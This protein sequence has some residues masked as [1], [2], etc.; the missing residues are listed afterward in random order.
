MQLVRDDT[1][2]KRE[3]KFFKKHQ[4]LIG[5]YAKVLKLLKEDYTHPSLKL[6]PLKGK[7][8][9]FH[10]ISLT[11]EYRIILILKIKEEKIYL[12]DIGTHD[13]VYK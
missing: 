11:Y 4:N 3:I 9:D 7:L 1:Y 2:I 12:I 10:A 6:H 13:T 5:K 8:Q